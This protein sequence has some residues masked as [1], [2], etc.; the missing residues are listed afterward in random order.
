MR[1]I[2]PHP[3]LALALLAMWLLL[4]QSIAPGQ[5]LLGAGIALAASRAM[6][7]LQPERPKIR[8]IG[9]IIKLIGLVT[10]DIARSN[11]AVT[12]I[13]FEGRQ[14]GQTDGFLTVPLLLTDRFAL[15]ILAC[16]V[17]ATPG[18]AWLEYDARNNTVLIHVLDLVDEAT[19][20]DTL[21]NRYEALLLEIFQ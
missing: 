17:T 21:K 3:L 5:I 1:H 2:L 12:R 11:I 9:K 15:A 20:I 16:I 18:S 13:I 8:H 14:R 7:A 4:Q 19:W 6:A 10:V